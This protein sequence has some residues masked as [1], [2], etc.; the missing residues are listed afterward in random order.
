MQLRIMVLLAFFLSACARQPTQISPTADLPTSPSAT[1][2]ILLDKIES[3]AIA[4]L[5]DRLSLQPNLIRV[6]S[7]ESQ[8]WPDTSLGC[9][10]PGKEYA[11]QTVPGYRLQLEADGV[12]YIYH[13]DTKNAVVLCMEDDLPSFPVTPGEIDDAEPWMPVE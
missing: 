6:I 8:L 1:A 9:P 3:A 2:E 11:Q 12:G 10:R 7:V 5:S 13:T 4:D